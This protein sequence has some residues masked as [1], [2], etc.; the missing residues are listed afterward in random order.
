MGV[1]PPPAP[2][3]AEP[4]WGDGQLSTAPSLEAPA[5]RIVLTVTVILESSLGVG[6]RSCWCVS[7]MLLLCA[8][9]YHV[10]VIK[11]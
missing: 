6:L 1:D 9:V 3:A 11:T 4:A 5:F 7:H 8:F 2:V 10:D